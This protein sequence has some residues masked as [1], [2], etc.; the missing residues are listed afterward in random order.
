MHILVL[1][2]FFILL[3]YLDFLLN[4]QII[5]IIIIIVCRF[6]KS[7]PFFP[8]FQFLVCH[9][10]FSSFRFYFTYYRIHYSP[11]ISVSNSCLCTFVFFRYFPLVASFSVIFFLRFFYD[12]ISNIPFVTYLLTTI[13]FVS[14]EVLKL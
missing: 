13:M 3:F 9:C 7:H 1:I 14:I 8:R 2:K 6:S 4:A 11:K 5:I 12:L 10:L